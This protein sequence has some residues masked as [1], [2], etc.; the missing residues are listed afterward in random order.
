[1]S[2]KA[3]R[4]AMRK[5]AD[6]RHKPTRSDADVAGITAGGQPLGT[7]GSSNRLDP[8]KSNLSAIRAKARTH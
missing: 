1:M 7:R 5:A 4:I 6:E 8:R 2:A 3:E